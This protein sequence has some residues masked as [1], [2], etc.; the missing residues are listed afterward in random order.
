MSDSEEKK[1]ESAEE[2]SVEPKRV[3]RMEQM[4]FANKKMGIMMDVI[5][6]DGRR[7]K[8]KLG[9]NKYVSEKVTDRIALSLFAVGAIFNMLTGCEN[10][11]N[12]LY[13][14]P[15]FNLVL[16]M[17]E[18]IYYGFVWTPITACIGAAVLYTCTYM[19]I[20]VLTQTIKEPTFV[21][22]TALLGVNFAAVDMG[23]CGGDCSG[24]ERKGGICD[25]N[26]MKPGRWMS[27]FMKYAIFASVIF[28]G[29]NIDAMPVDT[30]KLLPILAIGAAMGGG[31]LG[32]VLFPCE[33][34]SGPPGS[35]RLS[36]E[37]N[38]E[39]NSNGRK[40]GM[41]QSLYEKTSFVRRLA[42]GDTKDPLVH[43]EKKCTDPTDLESK[44]C[45]HDECFAICP[46]K[47]DIG[48]MT[49]ECYMC[50]C[51]K[52]LLCNFMHYE[53]M[54]GYIAP[55]QFQ[56][57][58]LIIFYIVLLRY[59]GLTIYFV[60][61]KQKYTYA[62]RLMPANIVLPEKGAEEENGEQ[63]NQLEDAE[64]PNISREDS[65]DADT[66]TPPESEPSEPAV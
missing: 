15:K 12:S 26:T 32:A 53:R 66:V 4:D 25:Y 62:L 1:V 51:K 16:G 35:R 27:E 11:C 20:S 38:T 17:D 19:N 37:I 49:D 55:I 61:K 33:S 30:K 54:A 56:Q 40:E 9:I 7:I 44:Y 43:D 2:V 59:L 34:K 8:D 46:P 45:G 57:M 39:L 58:S 36:N 18:D 50:E 21:G 14:K 41:K 60:Y 63:V 22:L 48:Q 64:K 13:G 52:Q 42:I 28:L 3:F 10:T 31:T 47:W 5:Q 65:G 23:S 6:T 24:W 29:S